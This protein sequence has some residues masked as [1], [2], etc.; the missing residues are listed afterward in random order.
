MLNINFSIL[1]HVHTLISTS[2]A[3]DQ[4]LYNRYYVYPARK[5]GVFNVSAHF[6]TYKPHCLPAQ[7]LSVLA[8]FL[9]P[10]YVG[11]K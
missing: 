6:L 9:G 10:T 1:T 3:L 4:Q 11:V 8:L 5:N 2:A 7:D